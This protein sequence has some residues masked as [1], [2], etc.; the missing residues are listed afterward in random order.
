MHYQ[1][2]LDLN[3]G[4]NNSAFDC[5]NK[6][7]VIA[8]ILYITSNA[9]SSQ[10]KAE[11]FL[12]KFKSNLYWFSNRFLGCDLSAEFKISFALF[13]FPKLAV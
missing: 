2:K 6:E 7:H 11:L 1:Y 5:K 12:P 4:K 9:L 3:L 13:V 10:S 8:E